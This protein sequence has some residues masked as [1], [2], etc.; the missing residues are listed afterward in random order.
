MPVVPLTKKNVLRHY[1]VMSGDNQSPPR[2]LPALPNENYS[3]AQD[4]YFPLFK[5]REIWGKE[6]FQN[7]PNTFKTG[8][9]R[10]HAT[11]RSSL[12][13]IVYFRPVCVR[14][15]LSL[16]TIT[17]LWKSEFRSHQEATHG[18]MSVILGLKYGEKGILENC[19]L[20]SLTKPV[21]FGF[22]ERTIFKKK[23]GE[24]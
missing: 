8:W 7:P 4:I 10:T 9:S 13:Y 21:S 17:Y 1:H 12:G 15:R 22:S 2:R 5:D 14:I 11:D 6:K 16:K 23:S 3:P 20:V 18:G 24:P 19:L